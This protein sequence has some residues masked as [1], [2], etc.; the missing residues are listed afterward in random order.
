MRVALALAVGL[1]SAAGLGGCRTAVVPPK[2][3]PPPLHVSFRKS[4]IPTEGM[5]ASVNNPS[6]AAA[7]KVVAVFVRGKG[8][9][10]ER[11]YRLD[12]EI[13]PL[14]SI[15][16][17]W[18]EFGGWKLKPGDKLRIRCEG[19]TGDLACEVSD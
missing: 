3:G 9:K 11:S 19:Y 4:Q 6:E 12:R 13:K 16:V 2:A 18:V 1:L 8:E 14:D 10:E 7:L 17:G 5:V 15:S